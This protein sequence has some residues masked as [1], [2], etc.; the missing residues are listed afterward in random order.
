MST[1]ALAKAYA[2]KK[3][4]LLLAVSATV[5]K[6]L[7]A[8]RLDSMPVFDG[9]AAANG[10]LFLSATDGKVLCLRSDGQPLSAAPDVALKA[11]EPAERAR[12]G[13]ALTASHP[14]FKQLSQVQITAADL[15]WR[16]RAAG[17]Q[18]GLAL[19]ELATPLTKQA[20]FKFKL[21]MIPMDAS[22]DPPRNGFLVFG[23]TPDEPGLIKCG[24][25]RGQALIIQ[26]AY[27]KGNFA[28]EKVEAQLDE[29]ADVVVVVDLAAQKVSLTIHGRT[30]ETKLDHRLSAIK[31]IGY[32]ANS[33]ASEFSAVETSGQ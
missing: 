18:V 31:F 29:T 12:G 25:R 27:A 17:G 33:V 15:G 28:S 21:H 6:K 14:D 19:R 26:G 32:C 1:E 24:M 11:A 10:A 8:Y 5:G 23:E 7:A 16:V 13:V 3:G 9:L 30:V 2:G 22:K 20:T 4:A